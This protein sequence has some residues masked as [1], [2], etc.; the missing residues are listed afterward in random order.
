[1]ENKLQA[2]TK[3]SQLEL[4]SSIMFTTIRGNV[5]L[6]VSLHIEMKFVK[7]NTIILTCHKET[8]RKKILK[9]DYQSRDFLTELY[10]VIPSFILL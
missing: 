3:H 10:A 5:C 8:L 2:L 4:Q 7:K 6:P 9:Q 1:M